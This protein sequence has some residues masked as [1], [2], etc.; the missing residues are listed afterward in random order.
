M[1]IYVKLEATDYDIN[2]ITIIDWHNKIREN[3]LAELRIL[4]PVVIDD[5]SLVV[6]IIWF[7]KISIK[8]SIKKD[9]I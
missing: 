3:V 6:D 2:Q 5:F 8:K 4:I 7:H 1:V 9:F